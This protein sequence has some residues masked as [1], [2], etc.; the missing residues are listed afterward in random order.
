M[1]CKSQSLIHL[2]FKFDNLT[3]IISKEDIE[4]ERQPGGLKA[5]YQKNF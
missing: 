5:Y 4:D 3:N 2:K 1:P